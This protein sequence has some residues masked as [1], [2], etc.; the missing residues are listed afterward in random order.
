[1]LH[2]GILVMQP[3]ARLSRHTFATLRP[4]RARQQF[5]RAQARRP[6][7]PPKDQQAKSVAREVF[8]VGVQEGGGHKLPPLG[9][10][11]AQCQRADPRGAPKFL[12]QE[13]PKVDEQQRI[14]VA[15]RVGEVAYEQRGTCA[16]VARRPW[17]AAV[18]RGGRCHA[19]SD[20]STQAPK[21]ATCVHSQTPLPVP[22]VLLLVWRCPGRLPAGPARSIR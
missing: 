14:C 12:D 13:Q 20:G 3:T 8:P 18:V 21:G 1:M 10:P 17:R 19:Q 22:P 4:L 16:H 2:C 6:T 5:Q 7:Y 9:R 11:V 15:A